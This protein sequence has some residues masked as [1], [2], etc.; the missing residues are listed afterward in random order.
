MFCFTHDL[1]QKVVVR[2]QRRVAEVFPKIAV[3]LGGP[4]LESG[5]DVAAAVASLGGV[6]EA[7]ADLELLDGVGVGQRRVGQFAEGVVG[8]GDAVD[9]IVVVVF[10]AAVYV[11]V[12]APRPSCAALFKSEEA[13]AESVSNC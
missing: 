4:A 1:T 9:Q 3:E 10:S 5:V 2:V 8:Y 7:G 12:T 11:D 6:V 13:P